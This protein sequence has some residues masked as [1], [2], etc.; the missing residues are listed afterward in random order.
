MKSSPPTLPEND[1][2]PDSGATITVPIGSPTGLWKLGTVAAADQVG[3][4]ANLR[5][6][7]TV[8]GTDYTDVFAGTL[9]DASYTVT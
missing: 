3:N 8:N 6:W 2:I 7:S 9:L 1:T 5:R 4:G